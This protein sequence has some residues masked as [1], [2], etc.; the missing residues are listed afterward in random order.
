MQPVEMENNLEKCAAQ[1]IHPGVIQTVVGKM[2]E[3]RALV[4]LADFYKLFGD[5]TRVRILAA[6][7][8][9]ELCVCDLSIL[10]DMKQPAVSH[11]LR[12]LRQARIVKARR[13]GRVV[14]YSL[15]DDHIR[16][17]LSV[18]LEHLG[19]SHPIGRAV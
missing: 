14:Y 10:L 11:Q 4:Q 5:G 15:L 16:N 9:A 2:P 19:E 8:T 17:V 7:S 13:D 1:C 6:L 3:N 12:I 18:G